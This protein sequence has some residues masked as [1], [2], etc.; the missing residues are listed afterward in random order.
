MPRLSHLAFVAS[1]LTIGFSTAVARSEMIHW[2]VP[3]VSVPPPIPA[4]TIFPP[5]IGGI[6]P[7]G[8]TGFV[9][10]GLPY[11]GSYVGSVVI[12]ILPVQISG[13]GFINEHT[14]QSA[15]GSFLIHDLAS[16]QYAPSSFLVTASS[17]TFDSATGI[18]TI[19]LDDAPQIVEG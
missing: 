13:R 8:I 7:P 10:Y 4:Y 5:H 12:P 18:S 3:Q 11:T 14:G 16:D 9:N 2:S 17:G 6:D 1:I 15:L 19:R